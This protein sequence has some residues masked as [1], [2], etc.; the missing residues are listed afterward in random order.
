MTGIVYA[1]GEERMMAQRSIQ[2]AKLRQ[3][4]PLV[5]AV[6]RDLNMVYA[7]WR[8]DFQVQGGLFGLIAL[9]S[10]LGLYAYQRRQREFARREAAAAEALAASHRFMKALTDNIPGLVAYW[11]RELRCDFANK[12][13]LEWFGKTP[14]QMRGIRIQDLLGDELFRQNEPF[15]DAVLRGES[16]C[17]ERTLTKADGSV[18]HTWLT[19]FRTWTST[20]CAASSSWFR[21]SQNSSASSLRWRTANGN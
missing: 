6:A 16:Q 2:P 7:A 20:G 17:F 11:N 12:A 4:K 9:G 18:G 14:E 1:T 21:T 19:T 10:T 15:I 3:D 5:V 8:H 13:Y